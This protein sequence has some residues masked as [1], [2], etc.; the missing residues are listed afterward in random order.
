MTS[1]GERSMLFSF[2][3][4]KLIYDER[5]KRFVHTADMP[6]MFNRQSTKT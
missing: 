2:Q 3:E 4:D 1:M 5:K 6:S